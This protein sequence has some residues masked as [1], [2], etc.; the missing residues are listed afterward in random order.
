[1]NKLLLLL[2]TFT[3][4]IIFSVEPEIE[5]SISVQGAYYIDNNEGYD[6]SGGFDS[7]TYT[8]IE[9][10]DSFISDIDEGRDLGSGWGG[11]ELQGSY[12]HKRTYPFLQGVNFL[13]ADNNLVAE[14]SFNLSPVTFNTEG[15]LK[16]TPIAFLNFE[17]GG[18]VGTGWNL[19]FNGLG[20]NED[21]TGIPETESFPGAVFQYWGSGTFQF[22]LEAVWPGEWHH[23]VVQT[24]HKAKYRYFTGA[25]DTEAWQY[26]A[27][28]GK[29]FNGWNYVG[30]Y[31]IGYQMPL[32]IN[33]TGFKV[34]VDQLL[35]DNADLSTI[36]DEGWGSDFISI[37]I[38]HILNWKISETKSLLFLTEFA[39]ALEYSD[40][41]IFNNYFKNRSV[42]GDYFYFDRIAFVYEVKL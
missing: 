35:G 8:P 38:G 16:L 33:F 36:G 30:E 15:S 32:A 42:I 27:D 21:G 23:I 20:L 4:V 28:G 24:T 29:N 37:K 17:V 26:L 6:L 41:T 18:H 34:E 10:P 19:V 1:M 40:E 13:T 5:N 9:L 25:E 11:I 22:D 3:A 7:P 31:V 2:L 12:I 14:T 39:N